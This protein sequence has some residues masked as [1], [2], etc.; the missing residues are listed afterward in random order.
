MRCTSMK[1][2]GVRVRPAC[3]SSLTLAGKSLAQMFIASVS[4]PSTMLMTKAPTLPML[5]SVSLRVS[6]LGSSER[7]LKPRTTIAGSSENRLKKL[8]GAA[9]CTPS[10]LRLL[11]SA[12]GRGTTTADRNL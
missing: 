3:S 2:E 9:L 11:M 6:R 12:I 7:E 10:S 8:K 4:G 5:R 1:R